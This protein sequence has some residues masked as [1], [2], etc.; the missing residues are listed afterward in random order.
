[1]QVF[2]FNIIGDMKC[3]DFATEI[4]EES[5]LQGREEDLNKSFLENQD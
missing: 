2:K 5:Q 3:I 1:M 4:F